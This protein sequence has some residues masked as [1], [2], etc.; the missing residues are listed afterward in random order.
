MD[1]NT[2]I[3]L[4]VVNADGEVL[5]VPQTF[6]LEQFKVWLLSALDGETEPTWAV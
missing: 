2:L 4:K 3:E 1:E 6:T 5:S